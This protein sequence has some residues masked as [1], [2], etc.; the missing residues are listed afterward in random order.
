MIRI[1]FSVHCIKISALE[2]CPKN[3][4]YAILMLKFYVIFEI[5]YD[6][7]A[8]IFEPKLDAPF[9]NEQ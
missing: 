5:S 6:V 4:N 8:S 2:Y 9:L 3:L 1:F 7:M